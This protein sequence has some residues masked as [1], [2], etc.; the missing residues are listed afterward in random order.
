[1]RLET[2][3]YES[4]DWRLPGRN[5][6]AQGTDHKWNHGYMWLHREESLDVGLGIE[7]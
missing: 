5:V 3:R 6:R 4:H 7:A 2:E 1:M